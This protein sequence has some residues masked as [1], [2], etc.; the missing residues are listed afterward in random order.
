MRYA[1]AHWKRSLSCVVAVMIGTALLVAIGG[2]YGSLTKS[3]ATM[4]EDLY[5]KAAFE[6]T[7]V[8]DSGL[9]E[10]LVTELR[11]VD[12]V[13]AAEPIVKATIN[14]PRSGTTLLGVS[15]N[16]RVLD[17]RVGNELVQQA[18]Q[19][20]SHG[21]LADG[22][23]AGPGLATAAGGTVDLNSVPV[24]VVFVPKGDLAEKYNSG[25]Y[26][27]VP[28][29]MAQQFLH[30][31]GRV[32]SVFI[33]AKPGADLG[34]LN[35][36]LVRVVDHRAVVAEPQF[37]V[38]QADNSVSLTRDTLLLVGSIA[39]VV[40]M[41]IVF[42]TMNMAVVQRKPMIATLR[43]LGAR[44]GQLA[45]DLLLEVAVMGFLG[46]CAGAPLG[47]LLSYFAIK[48]LPPLML[49]SVDVKP[50]F[51]FPGGAVVVVI[52]LGVVA[53]V[54]GAAWPA[55]VVFKASPISAMRPAELES[56]GA[57]RTK[58][59]WAGVVLGA[60][61]TVAAFLSAIRL[62]DEIAF[63][64]GVLVLIGILLLCWALGPLLVAASGKL[65]AT[66]GPSGQVSRSTMT[67]SAKRTWA[68]VMI[69][70]IA[71]ALGSVTNGVLSNV[72]DS[73][74]NFFAPLA[75]ADVYVSTTAKDVVPVGPI[76]PVGVDEQLRQIPGVASVI[77]VQYAFVNV[78]N[79]R[80]LVVGGASGT[81]TPAFS[82]MNPSVRAKVAV[83]DGAVVSRQLARRLHRGVGDELTLSTPSGER[84][85]HILEVVDYLTSERGMIALSLPTMQTWFQRDGATYLEVHV[86]APKDA[87]RVLRQA[88][89]IAAAKDLF[90]YS[91]QDAVDSGK[92]AVAQMGSLAVFVQ[93]IVA[94]LA[95]MALFNAFMISVI[96]RRREIGVL[97]AMGASRAYIAKSI[98]VESS[99][100][101]LLGGVLG[102]LT[103]LVVHRLGTLIMSTVTAMTVRFSVSPVDLLSLLV[104]VIL[105]WSGALLPASRAAKSTIVDALEVE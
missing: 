88:E 37:R 31:P 77:P 72:V 53:C 75:K 81:V 30:Q 71:V 1:L 76:V 87:G 43:A 28:L 105:C 39:L 92:A 63:A 83:G 89:K 7:G 62:H 70:T 12:G 78:G 49:Q 74:G 36:A 34:T 84:S 79:D 38:T 67:Q 14:V 4:S 47:A 20:K 13:A 25:D 95:A 98:L 73:T 45:R 64:G 93:W 42:N 32:S 18:E 57:D 44:R 17:N 16:L 99:S 41:F 103:S 5:G 86:D 26:L 3:V 9:T 55:L 59:N 58:P 82:A 8:A 23:V 22:A 102:L 54:L 51:F 6:V 80:V 35:A 69:V 68:N 50:Q 56:L 52:A 91:G 104:A 24:K 100:V 96:E 40:A 10:S 90:A 85:V 66:M 48:R 2:I 60:T 29:P 15:S 27:I 46:G 11:G 97:R 65:A 21:S 61:L 101:A 19:D 33:V 94:L